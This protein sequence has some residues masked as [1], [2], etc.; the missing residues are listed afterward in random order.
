MVNA[1]D[2]D[3]SASVSH[4][5]P[6]RRRWQWAPAWLDPLSKWVGI[7]A[8]LV[9]VLCGYLTVAVAVPWPPF[10]D[11][12]VDRQVQPSPA[13]SPTSAAGISIVI[14]NKVTDG[15]SRTR[16]DTPAYLS[17]IP[18]NF[19]KR[20]GCAV[21]GTDMRTGDRAFA[22]CQTVGDFNTNGELGNPADD[23]NPALRESDQWYG[24]RW[25]DRR[26]GYLSEIWVED[27]YRGGLGLPKCRS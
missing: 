12:A 11:L 17:E 25:P 23:G 6:S 19:C 1:D 27:A 4:S 10:S 9:L 14:Y 24:I 22:V 20:D 8:T 21:D 5:A 15:A 7:I 2:T 3:R 18:A 13:R 26:F 16:E